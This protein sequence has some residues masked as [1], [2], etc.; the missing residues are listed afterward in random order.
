MYAHTYILY[1]F[2]YI[3]IY[4]HTHMHK[5][6]PYFLF[7]FLPSLWPLGTEANK[8]VY[9]HVDIIIQKYLS[10]YMSDTDTCITH[11]CVHIYPYTSCLL[12]FRIS[13]L[14]VID[15]YNI[16]ISYFTYCCVYVHDSECMHIFMSFLYSCLLLF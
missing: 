6:T 1:I 3:Y 12:F 4:T 2:I 9:I 5:H 8:Q 15:I 11:I 7:T 16:H 14:I 13:V 10:L